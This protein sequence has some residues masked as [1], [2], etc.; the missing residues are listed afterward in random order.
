M[1]YILIIASFVITVIA[2]FGDTWKPE[3]KGLDK[4][5]FKGKIALVSALVVISI[6]IYTEYSKRV[7]DDDLKFNTHQAI[8]VHAW[9]I[10]M[11]I[12]KIEQMN[13]DE[14][15]LKYIKYKLNLISKQLE[16]IIQTHTS[17]FEVNEIKKIENLI[18]FI[19][20]EI[21]KLNVQTSATEITTSLTD[22]TF[23]AR[24]IR[25][26]LCNNI[27]EESYFCFERQA[28]SGM[29][30]WDR[31]ND[32][33][34]NEAIEKAKRSFT[35]ILNNFETIKPN[36]LFVKIPLVLSDGT[37]EH[38]WLKDISYQEGFITGIIDNYVTGD[39]LAEK[40]DTISVKSEFISDWRL[41]KE[42]YEYGNFT[43]YVALNRLS[44]KEKTDFLNKLNYKLPDSPKGFHFNK[45]DNKTLEPI[46]NPRAA[47]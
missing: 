12:E 13:F 24:E 29:Q 45:H 39:T 44:T 20:N 8:A 9:E 25:K 17:S 32:V 5:N 3:N 40:G 21:F 41:R 38:V 22:L 1:E 33:E 34:M 4:L 35:E 26:D 6:S 30:F 16:R 11:L 2:L 28:I 18:L 42:G 15:K 7:K 36:E 23:N 10:E 47:F 46:K 19:E 31:E 27:M 14:K 37:F 43:L